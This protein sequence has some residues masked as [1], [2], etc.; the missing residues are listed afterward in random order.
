MNLL[1]NANLNLVSGG[2]AEALDMC[3]KVVT[4][5]MTDYTATAVLAEKEAIY[6]AFLPVIAHYCSPENILKVSF[7]LM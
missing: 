1:S 6:N 7:E 3:Q 4:L 2:N 5:F